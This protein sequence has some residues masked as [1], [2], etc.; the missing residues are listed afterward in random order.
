MVSSRRWR[1]R[2]R[3][4]SGSKM[5]AL[6]IL[7]VRRSGSL[8]LQSIHRGLHGGVRGTRLGKTLLDL[9]NRRVAAGPQDLQNLQFEPGELG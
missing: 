4:T 7:R 3:A 9:A 8:R 6:P 5:C 1:A 2:S